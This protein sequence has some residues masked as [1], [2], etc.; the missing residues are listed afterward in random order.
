MKVRI[1]MEGTA[2]LM[3]HNVRLA[4][5]LDSYAK[6]LKAITSKR[7]KTDEDHERIAR[8][9]FEGG[10][11][12]DAAVGP[13]VPGLAV[14]QSIV[15]GAR[16]TKAGKQIERG[17]FVLDDEVPLL[18]D[19]PRTVDGLWDAGYWS[20]MAVR[21]QSART[22]RTRPLFRQWSL[23]VDAQVDPGLVNLNDLQS[24]L[25]DA[26]TMTGLLEYR[27]RYGRFEA[28]VEEL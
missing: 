12:F 19:G 23:D 14:E 5:P 24:I 9:E 22:M 4:N 27:P 7:K 26:G 18:Y 10:L 21:V 20:T 25:V 15:H 28:K 1:T 2:P 16:I 17:L 3:M 11:Y 6:A 13:Y 8:L